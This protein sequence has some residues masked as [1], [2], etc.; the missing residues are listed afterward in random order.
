M[1]ISIFSFT[2][3]AADLSKKLYHFFRSEQLPCISY[4]M[5]AYADSEEI[6]P[7]EKPLKQ[8][9]KEYFQKDNVL[10]FISACGIAVRSIAPFIK[11][12]TTDPC[13][14]VIDE[15]GTYVIP[16]LSGHIGGGNDFALKTASALSAIPVISTATDLNHTFAVD[17]FAKKNNLIISDMAL[18]KKVSVS[19][20]HGIPV[21][22]SGIFVNN[23]FS[24]KTSLPSA[25]DITSPHSQFF[26]YFVRKAA[27]QDTSDENFLSDFPKTIWNE[28][29]PKGLTLKKSKFGISIQAFSRPKP[30]QETLYLI[31]KQIVLGIGCKKN[32]P[33]HF[34]DTFISDILSQ[35]HIFPQ[36]V[37]A[38]TSIDLKKEEPCLKE[39]ADKYKVPFIVYNAQTLKKI[40][41]T[42]S[43]SAFVQSITGVDNV[44]ERAALAYADCGKLFL[45]KTT[46]KGM[47]LAI[48]LLPVS[49]HFS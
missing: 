22:F 24:Q 48:S 20:L 43:S 12:K 28:K 6:F 41:G 31:P 23:T 18:A 30:Y 39:L 38:I 9:V 21:G 45:K 4:T 27:H 3:Q 5:E 13:V 16:L 8:Q 25:P 47:T 32:M 15:K 36:A 44:C 35:Y 10:I 11:D 26:S 40:N 46:R 1:T 42:F 14:L 19:L 2:K 29:L 37:A 17:V 49:I 34:L 33:F 7:F